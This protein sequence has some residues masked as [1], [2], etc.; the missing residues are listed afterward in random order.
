MA[1][2]PDLRLRNRSLDFVCSI[3]GAHHAVCEHASV[4]W[5]RRPGYSWAHQHPA[6]HFSACSVLSH[7]WHVFCVP[8]CLQA[9]AIP[10]LWALLRGLASSQLPLWP[11]S[12]V[13]CWSMCS[14]RRFGVL[15]VLQT[16]DRT[17]YC[18]IPY[19]IMPCCVFVGT[20][21]GARLGLGIILQG[22]TCAVAGRST[23]AVINLIS[24]HAYDI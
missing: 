7:V 16:L 20:S 3:T 5:C 6:F 9:S 15:G 21:H 12:Y 1:E 11:P 14:E 24:P 4:K 10:R 2:E 17:R 19:A 22:T 13:C 23:K 8:R 18:T